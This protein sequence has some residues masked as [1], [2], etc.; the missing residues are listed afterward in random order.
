MS[1][2]ETQL[3]L[4]L[5]PQEIYRLDNFL[6]AKQETKHALQTFC[7]LEELD[8]LYLAGESGTGKTHL[9]I[10]CAESVQQMGK[11]VIYLSLSELVKTAEPAALQ[12]I[13]QA[14]LLCL[15]D[16]DAIA[17]LPEWEEAVFHCFNRLHDAKGHLLVSAQQTPANSS[18]DLPDLRSRLATGLVYQLVMMTDEQKQQA[19]ILQAQSR[20]LMLT[21]D[22]AQYLL[23]HYGRD[24]PALM[25]VLQE[26]DKASL[27]AK[28]KLTI[29]FIRQ[30]LAN[31]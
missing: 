1:L 25:A 24:M 23:R 11:R 22:V 15:D 27:Q 28:R 8:F 7:Q 5:S 3:T 16:V 19:L 14:D 31:G 26:L 4:R 13:E 29:P 20:G 9:L 21:T 6:F 30:V 2:A 10:A 18:I 12:A 17:G